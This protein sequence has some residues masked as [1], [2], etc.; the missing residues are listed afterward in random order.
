MSSCEELVTTTVT[1]DCIRRANTSE[2]FEGLLNSFAVADELFPFG[3]TPDGPRGLFPDF[4]SRLF[5]QG[6]F[7]RL[8]FIAGTNL[9]EDNLF[10]RPTIN[11]TEDEETAYF[12]ANLAART[13]G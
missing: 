9:D 6:M 11:L 3:P 2:V 1:F 10:V 7:A 8:P 12:A 4:P 5:S 13:S